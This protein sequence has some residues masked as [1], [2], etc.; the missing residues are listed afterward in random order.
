MKD[1]YIGNLLRRNWFQVKDAN[2]VYAVGY[3]DPKKAIIYD[4]ME[5]HDRNYHITKDRK[6]RM[7][8]K[9][10]TGW[11]CQMYLDRY[12]RSCGDMQ[13]NLI[14]YDQST[15]NIY[16]YTPDTGNWI[17]INDAITILSMK[18]EGVYAAIGSRDLQPHGK[19]FIEQLYNR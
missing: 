3:L 7:G 5:G 15:R 14:F 18:P 17:I 2:S 4:P 11:A 6:D 1:E 9:G 12:R 19:A 8:V 13:F 10:G 16:R